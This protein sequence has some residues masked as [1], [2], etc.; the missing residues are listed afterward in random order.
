M[1]MHICFIPMGRKRVSIIKIVI[2]KQVKG[3]K[4]IKKNTVQ[5]LDMLTET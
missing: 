5:N 1:S 3:T 4:I 2:E